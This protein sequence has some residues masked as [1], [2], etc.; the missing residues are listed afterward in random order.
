VFLACGQAILEERNQIP[1]CSGSC[2]YANSACFHSSLL[3]CT[4]KMLWRANATN[5]LFIQ[6]LR[7]ELLFGL[8]ICVGLIAC[9][10]SCTLHIA[11]AT[12]IVA[13]QPAASH[14]VQSGGGFCT[15]IGDSKWGSAVLAMSALPHLEATRTMRIR[16]ELSRGG[17]QTNQTG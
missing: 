17:K 12:C 10:R 9:P 1:T 14:G 4:A 15:A 7:V 13:A 8:A 2:N 16:R 11:A 5:N 3:F 6:P